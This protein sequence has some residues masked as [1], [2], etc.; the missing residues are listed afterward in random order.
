ML[1]SKTGKLGVSPENVATQL[2]SMQRDVSV[3]KIS[4]YGIQLK[5]RLRSKCQKK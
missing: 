5:S 1:R 2:E 4:H 3:S